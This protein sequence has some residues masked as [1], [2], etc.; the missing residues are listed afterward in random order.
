MSFSRILVALNDLTKDQVVF[1]HSLS[2]A[3][4]SHS[5]LRLVHCLSLDIYRDLGPMMDA[6][7]GLHSQAEILKTAE[8]EHLIQIQ[9]AQTWLNDLRTR[10]VAQDIAADFV[11][12]TG[13]P[14]TLICHLATT[15]EADVVV[16]GNSGKKGLRRLLLGSVSNYVVKHSPALTI[17]VPWD[18]SSPVEYLPAEIVG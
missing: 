4:P 13:D 6:G 17:V 10:A 16:V 5:Q 8:T 11:C 15:W 12:A 7:V 14:G 9:A 1:S 2:L 3:E 18:G